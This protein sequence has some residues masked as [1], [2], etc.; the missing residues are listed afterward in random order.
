[1]AS[2]ASLIDAMSRNLEPNR[3]VPVD[4]PVKT[5]VQSRY[6]KEKAAYD[7]YVNRVKELNEA[8]AAKQLQINAFFEEMKTKED[9]DNDDITTLDKMRKELASL[10]AQQKQLV[11]VAEPVPEPEPEPEPVPE[12]KKIKRARTE[13]IAQNITIVE[14][15]EAYKKAR[16]ESERAFNQLENAIDAWHKS[17]FM[18]GDISV[19]GGD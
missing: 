2:V 4:A 11:P 13:S 6:E 9:D 14:A 18:K 16:I 5:P 19:I 12:P 7:A 3:L 15:F 10:K 8:V 17:Q 1:M